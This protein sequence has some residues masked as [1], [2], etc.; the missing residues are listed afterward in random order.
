MKDI[1]GIGG[2]VVM[3]ALAGLSGDATPSHAEGDGWRWYTASSPQ[4][5]CRVKLRDDLLADLPKG[6]PRSFSQY[7][8]VRLQF[9][10]GYSCDYNDPNRSNRK[11]ASKT[12]L[13]SA[14]YPHSII[15]FVQKDTE[16]GDQR[17]VYVRAGWNKGEPVGT[18]LIGANADDLGIASPFHDIGLYTMADGRF[19]NKKKVTAKDAGQSLFQ[20]DEDREGFDVAP[21]RASGKVLGVPLGGSLAEAIKSKLFAKKDVLYG[22]PCG[23]PVEVIDGLA[24]GRRVRVSA[25]DGRIS[26][27]TVYFRPSIKERVKDKIE[28]E[29]RF[30][31]PASFYGESAD[32][33]AFFGSPIADDVKKHRV[34]PVTVVRKGYDG[35]V[36]ARFHDVQRQLKLLAHLSECKE[37]A[38][39]AVFGVT[40]EVLKPYA[41]AL[42][43]EMGK[44]RVPGA[45]SAQGVSPPPA[46][47]AK[48]GGGNE[49]SPE[50]KFSMKLIRKGPEA[51]EFLV[52]CVNGDKLELRNETKTGKW[53]YR[54]IAKECAD[55]AEEIIDRVN[56][57]CR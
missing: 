33:Y 36:E 56:S 55:T 57:K 26:E 35:T 42:V 48:A 25:V 31:N 10:S 54:F 2:F 41:K 6:F 37:K 5:S 7:G 30:G 28:I 13:H 17:L 53:C 49:G 11:L 3:V 20:I 15:A 1:F 39:L 22:K 23:R 19:V 40:G 8:E 12:D 29:R 50:Q 43:E 45:G 24:S 52:R 14:T 32:T 27:V 18:V 47:D 4:F 38:S 51:R 44:P 46:Q 16:G 34:A 21:M 9:A